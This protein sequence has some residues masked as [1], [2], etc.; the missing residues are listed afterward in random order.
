[1]SEISETPSTPSDIEGVQET[2]QKVKPAEDDESSPEQKAAETMRAA[3]RESRRKQ[4]IEAMR[5]SSESEQANS[6]S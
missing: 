5:G 2:E 1:M 3:A 4:G 6:E